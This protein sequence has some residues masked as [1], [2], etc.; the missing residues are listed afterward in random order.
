M[1]YT[2]TESP[3]LLSGCPSGAKTAQVSGCPSGAKPLFRLPLWGKHSPPPGQKPLFRLSPSHSPLAP[4]GQRRSSGGACGA[5][6]LNRP[7]NGCKKDVSAFLH[8][9]SGICGVWV[10]CPATGSSGRTPVAPAFDFPDGVPLEDSGVVVDDGHKPPL[11]LF[12][13]ADKRKRSNKTLMTTEAL[14][15]CSRLRHHRRGF[16]PCLRPI[17]IADVQDRPA[18]AP[19]R[20]AGPNRPAYPGAVCSRYALTP[21]RLA[22]CRREKTLVDWISNAVILFEQILSS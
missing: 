11:R 20:P 5:R 19:R 9:N 12:H 17:A 22:A 10:H 7:E 4:P 2:G 14:T 18:P 15:A 1:R 13:D 8:L 16:C 21:I 6:E 3:C